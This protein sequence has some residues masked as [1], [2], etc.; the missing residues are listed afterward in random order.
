AK[1]NIKTLESQLELARLERKRAEALLEKESIPKQKYDQA[2]T[3][4]KVVLYQLE[5][6]KKNLETAV[7][8]LKTSEDKVKTSETQVENAKLLR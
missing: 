7:A 1:A 5:A 2:I 6:A 3:Q 4:E 8:S